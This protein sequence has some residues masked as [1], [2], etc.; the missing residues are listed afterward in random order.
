MQKLQREVQPATLLRRPPFSGMEAGHG[1][2][3]ASGVT[4]G[5]SGAQR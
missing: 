2:M 3:E 5:I 4:L 1:S